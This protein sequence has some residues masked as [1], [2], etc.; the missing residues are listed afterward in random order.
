[1]TPMGSFY[2]LRNH[3]CM[4]STILKVPRNPVCRFTQRVNLFLPSGS[5]MIVACVSTVASAAE[6]VAFMLIFPRVPCLS[7]QCFKE[8]R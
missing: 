7:T 2:Q 5:I 1:M 8:V 3:G 4:S 6:R